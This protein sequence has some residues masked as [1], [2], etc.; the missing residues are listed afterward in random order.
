MVRPHD[1][2]A[3]MRALDGFT[4]WLACDSGGPCHIE[5]ASSACQGRENWVRK[6]R[7][8][9]VVNQDVPDGWKPALYGDGGA[10]VQFP[11]ATRKVR[12]PRNR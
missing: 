1:A 12:A 6:Y 9:A 3:V 10:R 8:S 2:M 11:P 5:Y 7:N 4:G